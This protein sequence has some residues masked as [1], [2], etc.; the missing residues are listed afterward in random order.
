MAVRDPVFCM[1]PPQICEGRNKRLQTIKPLRN[2]C[3]GLDVFRRGVLTPIGALTR[4]VSGHHR[5][6]RMTPIYTLP[7]LSGGALLPESCFP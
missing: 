7:R 4:W 3:Q 2:R 1:A 5:G 6:H